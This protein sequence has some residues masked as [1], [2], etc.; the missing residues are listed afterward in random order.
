MIFTSIRMIENDQAFVRITN[1]IFISSWTRERECEGRGKGYMNRYLTPKI[2]A[3]SRR[4]IFGSNQDLN[5]KF[6][7]N[8]LTLTE[9]TFVIFR[10]E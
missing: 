5:E 7:A 3:A 6:S 10:L 8:S 9:S 2:N 4:F 1:A